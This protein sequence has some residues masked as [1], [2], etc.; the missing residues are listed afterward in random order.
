ME[1][2]ILQV[3]IRQAKRVAIMGVGSELRS[4]DAAGMH[5]INELLG[6][7]LS[8]LSNVCLIHGSTAPENFTGE[9]KSFSPDILIMVD[10]ANMDLPVGE[11]KVI[12]NCDIG[13]FSF[14]T[15]MLPLPIVMNYLNIES[16]FET[17]FIGIQPQ[18]T[19]FGFDLSEKVAKSVSRLASFL[20]SV[21]TQP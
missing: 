12:D 20:H 18:N 17:I 10:A 6:F 14:S 1:L 9:I 16:S 3:K 2:D 4:D 19:D 11:I 5:L 13:G 7:G 8:K 15:H 21:I